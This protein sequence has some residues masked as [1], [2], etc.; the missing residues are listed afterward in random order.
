MTNVPAALAWQ[1]SAAARSVHA[2]T[3]ALCAAGLLSSLYLGWTADSQLPEDVGYAGGFAAGWPHLLNQP[4]Y[5]TFLSALL[6][7]VTSAML[8]IRTDRASVVFHTL[9]LAGVIQVII[10][11]VVFNLLLRTDGELEGVWLFNDQVLH[12]AVPVLVPVVWL[13]LG[14]YGNVSL[15]VVAAS[16]VLPMIWLAATLLR[17][18]ALDWYPYIILDV[19]GRGWSGVA[20]YIVSILVAFVLMAAA[21]WLIDRRVVEWAANRS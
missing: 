5:F 10:T 1:H 16:T 13:V 8:A 6:A 15:R 17:G 3:A 21:M 19:P 14:P 7:C 9:R 20:P 11:G 2:G 12:L 18:P 4:A